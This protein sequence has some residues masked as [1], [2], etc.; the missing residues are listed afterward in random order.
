MNDMMEVNVNE[1]DGQC[2]VEGVCGE[3][4]GEILGGMAWMPEPGTARPFEVRYH[5]S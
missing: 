5:S 2:G 4:L 1:D 3:Y